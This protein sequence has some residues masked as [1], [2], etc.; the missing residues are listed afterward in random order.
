MKTLDSPSTYLAVVILI[1][2]LSGTLLLVTVAFIRRWQQLRYA[3]YVHILQREYRPVLS[4]I[5]SGVPCPT[6]I[7]ALHELSLADLELVLDPYFST[8]ELTERQRVFLQAACAELGMISLWQSRTAVSMPSAVRL[9]DNH[10]KD[11]STPTAKDS[12]SQ[13]KSI[14]NLGILG[15]RPSWKILA[16][17]LDSRNADIQLVALRSLAALRA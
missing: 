8:R 14:R 5:L 6:A 3:R 1:S 9:T 16:K 11:I 13:A 10:T 7:E 15:H 2:V 4:K 12:L 17:A